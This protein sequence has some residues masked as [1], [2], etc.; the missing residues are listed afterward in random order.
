MKRLASVVTWLVALWYLGTDAIAY[1]GLPHVP[2]YFA[3]VSDVAYK[4]AYAGWI[5]VSAAIGLLCCVARRWDALFLHI[6]F[7]LLMLVHIGLGC[8]GAQ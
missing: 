7:T 3:T 6:V 4:V 8:L 2:C 1:L 5:C